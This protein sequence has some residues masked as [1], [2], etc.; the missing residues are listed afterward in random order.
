MPLVLGDE[1]TVPVTAIDLHPQV[2]SPSK[3]D[4]E[5]DLLE[6]FRKLWG[7]KLL[8]SLTTAA[9]LCLAALYAFLAT[10]VYQVQ[11]V[12]RPPQIKD[13]DELNRT[14]VYKLSTLEALKRV[15]SALDS[16]EVRLNFFLANPDLFA[17][18]GNDNVTAEQAF[19]TFNEGAFQLIVPDPKKTEENFSPYLGLQITYPATI[20]GV[21]ILNNLVDYAIQQEQEK[22]ERDVQIIIANR[23]R[24]LELSVTTSRANYDTSKEARIIQLDEADR[25]KRALLQDELKALRT[26]LKTRRDNRILQLGEAIQIAD[27][28][29]IR[30]PTTPSALGQEQRATQGNMVRTEVNNQHIPL[31]FMGTEALQAER[32]ALLQ[33]KSDDFTESRIGEILKEL[34][35]LENN[36]QIEVLKLRENEDLFLGN[37]AA[38]KEEESRLRNLKVDFDNLQLVTI[39]QRAIEPSKPIKP[40]KTLI[41]ALGLVLG[42]MLGVFIALVRGMVRGAAARQPRLPA[43]V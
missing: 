29:G 11:S 30:K 15:G 2:V 4:D 16:Y 42:G 25:L 41:I 33:R 40:K 38:L 35:L 6:L 5:I 20:D 8:I 19:E 34:Q 23:L 32:K 12:L 28:L 10:P 13:L 37:L 27:A 26:Q 7:Q 31:Y 9:T 18:L 39:D 14:E 43:S 21:K 24:N 1:W 3:S 22:L 17:E 36:R